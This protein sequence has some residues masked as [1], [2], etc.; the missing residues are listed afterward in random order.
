MYQNQNM[1]HTPQGV[2]P[3]PTATM[4]DVCE[5]AA[6]SSCIAFD[7]LTTAR[8]IEQKLIGGVNEAP[9]QV[10]LDGHKDEGTIG[11]LYDRQMEVARMLEEASYALIRILQR[12]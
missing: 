1:A 2:G 10:K 6:R 3:V 5:I 11:Y 9:Q 7:V 4:G 8:G 12:Q